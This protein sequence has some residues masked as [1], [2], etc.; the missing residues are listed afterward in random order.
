MVLVWAVVTL[1]LVYAIFVGDAIRTWRRLPA[2]REC[3]GL[4]TTGPSA[5]SAHW[6]TASVPEPAS[7]TLLGGDLVVLSAARRRRI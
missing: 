4:P 5:M 6:T 3:Q 2:R 7:L 1:A